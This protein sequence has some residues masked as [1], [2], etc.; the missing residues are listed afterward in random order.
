MEGLRQ[1]V[2]KKSR[3]L[4]G[5]CQELGANPAEE[6]TVWSKSRSIVTNTLP[7]HFLQCNWNFKYNLDKA[8]PYD[9]LIGII[10]RHPIFGP[11]Y[12]ASLP[13]VCWLPK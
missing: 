10:L 1:D 8:T 11:L 4:S 9:I 6:D 2:A 12:F 7:S 13:L 5:A 3:L